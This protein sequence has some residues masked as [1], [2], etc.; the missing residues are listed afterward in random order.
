MRGQAAPR[1]EQTAF[2]RHF[3]PKQLA[4]LWL[5]HESTVR[6]MFIDEPGVLKYGKA[7]RHDGRRDYVTLRIPE[8]VA[9]RVYEQQAR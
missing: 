4:D 5:F 9:R 2:E 3:T 1:I 8:S 6:R 7:S